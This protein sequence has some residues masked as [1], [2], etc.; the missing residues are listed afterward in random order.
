MT[1]DAE[2]IVDETF[3]DVLI[4]SAGT[5]SHETIVNFNIVEF[6]ALFDVNVRSM[7]LIAKLC[8][9]H[10]E[11]TRGNTYCECMKTGQLFRVMQCQRQR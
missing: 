9:P 11:K 7:V 8:V 6:D 4:Q 2:R 10:S 5:T 3:M 1:K